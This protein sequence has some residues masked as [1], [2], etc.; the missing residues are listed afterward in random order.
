VEIRPT[1]LP[2]VLLIQ[3][4]VHH[5]NRGYLFESFRADKL[6]AAGLPEFVQENQSSSV[7]RTLRGLHYQLERP[8]A[9]LV[10][11][12]RGAILDVAVDIRRGSP[13]FGRWVSQVLSAENQLQLYIPVGF[14][15]GFCV[16]EGPGDQHG[17]VHSKDDGADVLYKCSD[18]YSGPADQKGVVWNDPQL[19]I[20]WPYAEPVVSAKDAVLPVFS[21]D[22]VDF[23]HHVVRARP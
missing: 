18:Y 10:R 6:R 4:Q 16:L 22:R 3:P 7:S 2:D 1:S 23:P 8:Q 17:H 14:A 15:H 13:T 11:V 19:A 5:D 12:L 9:K 20:Q 21:P